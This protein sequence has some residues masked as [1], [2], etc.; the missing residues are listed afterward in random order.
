MEEGLLKPENVNLLD[1]DK[2]Y[3]N[4]YGELRA[5]DNYAEHLRDARP[6]LFKVRGHAPMQ[7]DNL[8]NVAYRE[9]TTYS[10]I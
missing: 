4:R 7:R 5:P 6:H 9:H 10:R 1:F 8:S 2:F 3:V